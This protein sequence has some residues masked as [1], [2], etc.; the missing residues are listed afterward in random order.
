MPTS[1]KIFEALASTPR[2]RILALVA[3]Q[4]LTAG[5]IAK[6]FEMSQ[7][8][9]SK[10]LSLLESAGL[11]W[12]KKEGQF[13]HYGMETENLQGTLWSF[14]QEVCPPSRKIKAEQRAQKADGKTGS[15]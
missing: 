8:A 6:Q 10:H 4:S 14:M 5:E 15:A 11:V 2:R 13:V 1:E 9:V 12:R 7:P 3:E